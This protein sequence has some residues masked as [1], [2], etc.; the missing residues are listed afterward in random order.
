MFLLR[1]LSIALGLGCIGGLCLGCDGGRLCLNLGGGDKL[2]D[3]GC[4]DDCD[5][6]SCCYYCCCRR[7]Q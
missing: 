2:G 1:G 3:D 4:E 6:E 7:C 5:D